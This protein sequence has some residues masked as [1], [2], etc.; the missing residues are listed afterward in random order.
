MAAERGE[1]RKGR[2]SQPAAK[3]PVCARLGEQRATPRTTV[4]G[5]AVIVIASETSHLKIVRR[6]RPE[7]AVHREVERL[8][9][10][11]VHWIA[12]RRELAVIPYRDGLGA[13]LA[14][15]NTG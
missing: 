11:C 9:R 4:I 3:F 14:I 13:I 7:L 1:P 5:A 2:G 6:S 15:G 10:E 8:L 12:L